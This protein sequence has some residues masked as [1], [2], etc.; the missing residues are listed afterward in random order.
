MGSYADQRKVFQTC[1][2]IEHQLPRLKVLE[3]SFH[4]A[5]FKRRDGGRDKAAIRTR[6]CASV[7]MNAAA[8]PLFTEEKAREIVSLQSVQIARWLDDD[9][10]EPP[11]MGRLAC[12]MIASTD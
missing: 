2:R 12:F 8:V 7:D 3:R 6:R 10:C 9:A 5:R 1:T 4:S 11:L